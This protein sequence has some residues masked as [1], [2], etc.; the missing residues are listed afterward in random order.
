MTSVPAGIHPHYTLLCEDIRFEVSNRIS[1]IGLFENVVTPQLPV[2]MI[3]TTVLTYWHGQGS[4]MSEVRVLSP[5][6]S[7]IIAASNPGLIDLTAGGATHNVVFFVNIVLPEQ[8]T[9]WI[10]TVLDSQVVAETPFVVV[11]A[12]QSPAPVSTEATFA[13]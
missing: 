6:R 1:L 3:K 12:Q 2:S 13:N 9:Y 11:L 5:D 4:G 8:G 7:R 10:Q